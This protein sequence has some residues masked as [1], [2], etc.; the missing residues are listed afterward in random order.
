MQGLNWAHASNHVI[1]RTSCWPILALSLTLSACQPRQTD[2]AISAPPVTA[3]APNPLGKTRSTTELS[4]SPDAPTPAGQYASPSTIES[5]D[6]AHILVEEDDVHLPDNS[7]NQANLR[8]QYETCAAASG[9]V[10]PAI[11]ACMDE[12]FRWQQARLRNAWKTIADGPDSIYKDELA[13]EQDAYMR[14]TDRYCRFDPTTQGQGQMLDARSCRINRY[15]NRADAL[16][17]LI[18]K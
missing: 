5:T 15:A 2:A 1:A 4:T 16:E 12:E 10:T 17:K 14:D 3:V 13:D 11:Q 9:G 18:N 8:A 7:Y 6:S